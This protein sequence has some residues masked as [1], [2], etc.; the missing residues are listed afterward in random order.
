MSRGHSPGNVLVAAAGPAILVAAASVPEL[1]AAG[2]A[3]LGPAGIRVGP[4]VALD[5]GLACRTAP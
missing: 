4:D 5:V 3:A 1:G 2:A